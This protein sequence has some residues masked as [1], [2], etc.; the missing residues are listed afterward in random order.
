MAF[1]KS[2]DYKLRERR[3]ERGER[4]RRGE[5]VGGGKAK[6]FDSY[7]QT[8]PSSSIRTSS[9]KWTHYAWLEYSSRELWRANRNLE[10][11]S[12]LNS[13]RNARYS[14]QVV[15]RSRSS[16]RL[17]ST[18]RSRPPPVGRPTTTTTLRTFEQRAPLSA[19]TALQFGCSSS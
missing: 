6:P 17:L 3:T 14:I 18:T 4:E 15:K 7:D 5:W 19:R 13:S 8:T 10:K 16:P 9:H 12:L 2:D 1:S 11:L